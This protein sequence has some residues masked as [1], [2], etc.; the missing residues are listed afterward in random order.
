MF[1]R[2]LLY[3]ILI[4]IFAATLVYVIQRSDSVHRIWSVFSPQP[5]KHVV[6]IKGIGVIG[7][8]Q[9]DEYQADDA[10]GFEYAPTTL[11]WIEQMVKSRH[12][13]FG[14]W[15]DWGDLS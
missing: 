4:T 1:F 8:S 7:D 11:N 13:N 9:S 14:T 5:E 2:R 6:A 12:I 15:Q 10:R 3:F